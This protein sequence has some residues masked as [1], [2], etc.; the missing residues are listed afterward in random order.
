MPDLLKLH[1]IQETRIR[2]KMSWMP[3]CKYYVMFLL[4]IW[5][6]SRLPL[7]VKK[8]T[9]ANNGVSDDEIDEILWVF[10]GQLDEAYGNGHDT[11]QFRTTMMAILRIFAN[12]EPGKLSKM[13]FRFRT[14]FMFLIRSFG[15]ETRWEFVN[16]TTD[17]TGI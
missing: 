12:I 14:R 2:A 11:E 4:F 5:I 1:S 17:K 13:L 10:I 3:P 15:E 6:S 9:I 16:I 8:A 7:K